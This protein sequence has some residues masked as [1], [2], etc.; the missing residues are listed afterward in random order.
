MPTHHDAVLPIA[1]TLVVCDGAHRDP[2]TG[3]WT[4]LGLFNSI[5]APEFPVT[6]AH[7]VVYLALTEAAGKLTLR[8][9]IVD[10]EESEDPIATVD[11]ELQVDNPRVVADLVIPI[12][13]VTF[14]AAGE[15]RL[16]VFAARQFLLERRI[17]VIGPSD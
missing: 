10:S 15:Y 13:E 4:L 9:Q 14:P 7:M 8:F 6:H 3:K 16:Q 1:L 17:L 12:R 2:A 5:R 11:A